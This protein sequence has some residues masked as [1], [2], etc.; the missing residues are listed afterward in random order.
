MTPLLPLL[1][2]LSPTLAAALASAPPQDVETLERKIVKGDTCEAIARELYGDSKHVDVIHRYN[3]WLGAQLPHHLEPGQALVLP[4]TLPPP[5]PDAEVTAAR[6]T[7]EARPP[8]AVDWS[9]A[10]PGLDLWRGWRVNTRDDASA[11]ITFRDQSRT[12]GRRRDVVPVEP[13]DRTEA[14]PHA[15]HDDDALHGP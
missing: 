8:E 15:S 12:L 1:P 10:Q 9:S 11:E 7:V 4:K 3:P 5:Q 6:R 14:E 13:R 2:L